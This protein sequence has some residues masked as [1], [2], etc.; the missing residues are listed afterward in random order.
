MWK[1]G[2]KHLENKNEQRRVIFAAR[3]YAAINGPA[4]THGKADKDRREETKRGGQS[5]PPHG[6]EIDKRRINT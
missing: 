2:E 6:K 1:S 5:W 3:F 4:S